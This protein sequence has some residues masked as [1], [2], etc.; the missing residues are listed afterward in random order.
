MDPDLIPK[1]RIGRRS[2]PTMNAEPHSATVL[3]VDLRGY[4]GIAERFPA[5]RV[6]RLLEELCGVLGLAIEEH[7]GKIYHIAGD[8]LMAGFGL[9]AAAHEGASE[10][11]AAGRQMLLQF[12]P[13]ATRWREELKIDTGIGIGIHLGEVALGLLGPSGHKKATLVGDTVNVAARL[14]NRARAGEV[15]FS[16]AVAAAIGAAGTAGAEIAFVQLPQFELRGRSDP[17][18]IWCVPA[19]ARGAPDPILSPSAPHSGT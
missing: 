11:L 19:L 15:L 1:I 2:P 18:D 7:R 10:A 9:R 12:T 17:L 8:G 3:F 13:I 14:C 6:A 5:P 4:T 16:D